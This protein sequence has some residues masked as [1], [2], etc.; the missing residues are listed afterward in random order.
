[1][2][3]NP[4]LSRRGFL[5]W[6]AGGLSIP[7][8]LALQNSGLAHTQ[9][10]SGGF[11]KAKSCIV[12]FAWGGM[13]H[14]DTFDPKPDAPRDIRGEFRPIRTAVGG[15][16]LSEHLPRLACQAR[17]L[18]VVRSVHHGAPGHRPAAYWNLT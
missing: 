9:R 10:G 17:R 15:L 3:A 5:R 14:L 7:A 2:D 1:M 13:S 18:A 4:L 6:G 16:E 8:W 12:L 11:G